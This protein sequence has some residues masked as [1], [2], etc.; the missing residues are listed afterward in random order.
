MV[1][2]SLITL[3]FIS[4]PVWA[5]NNPNVASP[6]GSPTTPPS[7]NRSGLVRSQSPNLFNS[8]DIVTGNVGGMYHFRGVVPYSSSYY[9]SSSAYS[10]VD[11]FL[12]RSYD[13]ISSDRAFSPYR[14]YYDPRRAVNSSVRADGSGLFSPII[15]PHGQN[16]PYTPPMLPQLKNTPYGR[17]RPLSMSASELEA[18][19]AKQ[20]D[21]RRQMETQRDKTKTS[22][23]DGAIAEKIDESLFFQRYLKPHNIDVQREK[24]KNDDESNKDEN[25]NKTDE[26]PQKKQDELKP[27]DTDTPNAEAPSLPRNALLDQYLAD[28]ETQQ[29]AAPALSEGDKAQAAALLKEYGTFAK[30]A[31]ARVAEYLAGGELYLKEGRFYKAADMFALAVL[32]D[33]TDARPF[34]GQAFALFAAGE[35]MS[36]AFYLSQA[37]L[38]NPAVASY[39]VDLAKLIGDRD[40]FENRIIEMTTW[41]ERSGSGELAFMAAFVMY[42]D[43]KT[44]KA[45]EYIRI[46]AEK[47]PNDKAVATLHAVILPD[48]SN[49]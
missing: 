40:V 8:N 33:A 26:Q 16:D 27:T 11:D 46:A 19:I 18:I 29:G 30:L 48:A 41:Q 4:L 1:R 34:A 7:A 10:S 15:T 36:S 42:H 21:V 49:P 13:P 25:L 28:R 5:V 20:M 47:M 44:Q 3:F 32:W 2:L 9:S 31:A 12:R 39:P 38:R 17:Q 22:S 24:S 37:I 14:S 6:V 43:G 35:Y 45:A 23:T